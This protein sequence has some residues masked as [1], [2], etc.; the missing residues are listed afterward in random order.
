MLDELETLT[1]QLP[2]QWHRG[3]ARLQVETTPKE[4]GAKILEGRAGDPVAASPAAEAN[5][6]LGDA[7]AL[8]PRHTLTGQPLPPAL[9][10]HRGRP[11]GWA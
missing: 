8:G 5:R 2:T 3:L 1:C 4:L 9:R 7:A 11:S 10:G 6:R